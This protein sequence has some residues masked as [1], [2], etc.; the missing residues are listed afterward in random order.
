MRGTM[1][2]PELYLEAVAFLL[3]P[4]LSEKINRVLGTRMAVAEICRSRGGRAWKGR[5][6]CLNKV[7][8]YT[9][10]LGKQVVDVKS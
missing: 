8:A 3:A 1:S 10:I 5:N 6:T 7:S 2:F 9:I 4:Q